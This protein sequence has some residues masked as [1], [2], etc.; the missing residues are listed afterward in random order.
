MKDPLANK[1][2]YTCMRH[3][4]PEVMHKALDLLQLTGNALVSYSCAVP[5]MWFAESSVGIKLCLCYVN[6]TSVLS[7]NF[8]LLY[9]LYSTLKYIV[10]GTVVFWVLRSF[11]VGVLSCICVNTE[12]RQPDWSATDVNHSFNSINQP[13]NRLDNSQ[14]Y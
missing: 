4:D 5:L 1:L 11:Y 13:I 7:M 14:L 3:G 12:S 6:N 9:V 2:T 10:P 8:V